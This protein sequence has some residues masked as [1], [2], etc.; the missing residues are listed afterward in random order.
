MSKALM[1]KA[2]RSKAKTTR[3]GADETPPRVRTRVLRK[4]GSGRTDT[5]GGTPSRMSARFGAQTANEDEESEEEELRRT[6]LPMNVDLPPSSVSTTD[7]THA[8]SLDWEMSR[9]RENKTKDTKSPFGLQGTAISEDQYVPLRN[10]TRPDRIS[11]FI[12]YAPD[13]QSDPGG[14]TSLRVEDWRVL[15]KLGGGE[16]GT[17][18]SIHS[19]DDATA[20]VESHYDHQLLVSMRSS[21][22][23]GPIA[24]MLSPNIPALAVFG[25]IGD[26][27]VL[28][29]AKLL[30][31]LS[32]FMVMIR[33]LA[34]DPIAKWAQAAA[35]PQNENPSVSHNMPDIVV[36]DTEPTMNIDQRTDTRSNS[37][38]DE[39]LDAA[40]NESEYCA[41]DIV[42]DVTGAENSA[43]SG[44]D[45]GVGIYRL[46]G[47]AGS[48][49][50]SYTPW[51][52]P[53][54]DVDA[55]LDIQ[56]G[57]DAA[58]KATIRSKTQVWAIFPVCRSRSDSFS[59]HSPVQIRRQGQEWLSTAGY[60]LDPLHGVIQQVPSLPR[61]LIQ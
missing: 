25:D 39:A 52:G 15:E 61:S 7:S 48:N 42:E 27:A 3:Q 57:T 45:S 9:L 49:E 26:S 23:G 6:L 12:I 58:Y 20:W 54:H 13:G 53:V 17:M 31:N 40:E 5:R 21:G 33:P 47:G 44:H 34:D 50:F 10:V 46:R 11:T 8:P 4:N 56:P 24:T 28:K 2:R 35:A 51:L 60:L 36:E 59:V 55:M 30:S 38:N 22:L 29:A 41:D 43:D 14:V 18:T 32:Q 16:G 19:P 1:S 37:T